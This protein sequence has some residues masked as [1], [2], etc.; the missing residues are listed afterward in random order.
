MRILDP[1]TDDVAL[2]EHRMS[3]ATSAGKWAG[4]VSL[5]ATAAVSSSLSQWPQRSGAGF[6]EILQQEFPAASW[7]RRTLHRVRVGAL[8]D[9]PVVDHLDGL[10]NRL[11]EI[12]GHGDSPV[13]VDRH[14]A[15]VGQA[16]ADS[17][18][19]C[20]R[21][22]C[23][24][25][26]RLGRWARVTGEGGRQGAQRLYARP[27]AG[28][29]TCGAGKVLR[30]GSTTRRWQ[31]LRHV[32]PA[33]FL[34]VL[35]RRSADISVEHPPDVGFVHPHPKAMVATTTSRSPCRN[36]SSTS[37]RRLA[38]ARVISGRPQPRLDQM[39]RQRL[40]AFLCVAP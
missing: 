17:S 11:L 19:R 12:S 1:D 10:D 34:V 21:G 37:R 23:V 13:G 31:G 22:A 16:I 3:D 4:S 15:R 38:A 18:I 8:D 35:V 32:R 20:S 28:M 33:K 39:L 9:A 14:T 26:S 2:S 24:G 25:V 27:G 6:A 7:Y 36:R 29:H 5:V 30:T 40:H